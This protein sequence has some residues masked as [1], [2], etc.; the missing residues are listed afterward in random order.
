MKGRV[1]DEEG[2]P[3]PGVNILVEGKKLEGTYTNFT[4]EYK[5][6]VAPNATL[7]YSFIGYQPIKIEV[8][9]Q[10]IIDV[11]LELDQDVLAEVVVVGYGTQTRKDITGS[12]ADVSG[13][14]LERV[15][16]DDAAN[17][18]TGRL[19]GVRVVQNSSE[20]GAYD[21]D[22]DIRGFGEPLYIID[23]IQSDKA[24]FSRLTPAD[25]E[26]V[27]VLKDGSAS[28][29]GVQA[30]NGVVLVTTHQGEVGDM[31]IRY[32]GRYVW[33]WISSFPE[34][35]SAYDYALMWTEKEANQKFSNT[36][37]N[38]QNINF[39]YT[40]EM[41][42][43]LRIGEETNN[44]QTYDHF[45]N[46][47]NPVVT[48]QQHNITLQGGGSNFRYYNAIGYNRN[49][50]IWSSGDLYTNKYNFRS[51]MTA[52][53][54]KNL[55]F[56]TNLSYIYNDDNRPISTTQNIL[57]TIWRTP[58]TDPFYVNNNPDSLYQST[59]NDFNSPVAITNSDISGHNRLE[60][61][62]INA[63]FSLNY[64]IPGVKGLS[65]SALYSRNMRTALRE[66]YQKPFYQYRG[67]PE[68]NTF[69]PILHNFPSTLTHD[70]IRETRNQYQ[71]KVNYN[72]KF[73]KHNIGTMFVT[74]MMQSINELTSSRSNLLIDM[75]HFGA[76]DSKTY[77]VTST[78]PDEFRRLGFIGR[79]NY[80][81]AGKYLLEVSG[82]LDGS[83]KFA[84][85]SR[86][87]LFPSVSAGWVISK[88]RFMRSLAPTLTFLK[89]RGSFA[90]LGSDGGVQNFEYLSGYTFPVNGAYFGDGYYP[91][92]D[93]SVV[94]NPNLTWYESKLY[95]VGIEAQ[96]WK[97]KVIF[98]VDVF[99]RDRENL[100]SSN[101]AI[102]LPGSHGRPLPQI[103][104]N[105][106]R[107]QGFD[108]ELG[109]KGKTNKFNYR[110]KGIFSYTRRKL[111]NNLQAP[112]G[113]AYEEWRTG[114][115]NRYNDLA[116][117]YRTDGQYTSLEDI[118][119]SPTIDNNGNK[120]VIP[121]DIKYLDLNGDGIVDQRDV[122]VIGVNSGKPLYTAGLN[123][124]LIYK[125]FDLTMLW[126]GGFKQ[127]TRYSEMLQKPF[128][129][130]T[131]PPLAHFKDR[132]RL[133]DPYDQ[134][135]EWI[136]GTFPAMGDRKNYLESDFWYF[137]VSY[138][139]LKN[140]E[141]GYTLPQTV[142]K[143]LFLSSLRVYINTYNLL[144]FT[145]LYD[146]VDPESPGSRNFGYNYPLT[147]NINAG[148][149]IQF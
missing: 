8:Q 81:Y 58:V 54:S 33:S 17:S 133:A 136:M 56:K 108:I 88:E 80:N 41:L 71:F 132:T 98:G 43:R 127:N 35:V 24:T 60:D 102:E 15:T 62:R 103:N 57:K 145:N 51:N 90:Q 39:T 46:V 73:G 53:F 124:S 3:M 16:V 115:S 7:I 96:L 118:G 110:F 146:F 109:Y 100:V 104:V 52:N 113:N 48:Q 32:S 95:N 25:I 135:S 130:G 38:F 12:V 94:A 147:K 114:K 117:G 122:T 47:V 85:S 120:T 30:A 134:N 5:I 101:A 116:W 28:V 2:L 106:D 21:T 49:N 77:R 63:N 99:R 29:Y 69:E 31:K 4:G 89:V 111:L 27:S 149:D 37:V 55:S 87:G 129:W 1:F 14:E 148:I 76:S 59:L 105:S 121:G 40:P 125:N 13:Y 91:A 68:S 128:M 18:L 84:P 50:G 112:F 140:I 72:G 79:F 138:V 45:S 142:S 131:A 36:E 19:S 83:T 61:H 26:T 93:I 20:P 42:E 141:L 75:P 92:L 6:K 10:E 119:N 22:I 86:W 23:G 11:T 126:Q 65:L 70:N 9:N 67:N 64:Q 44:G 143:R 139:R 66:I 144:T 82:R 34:T 123:I 137:D 74:D 78:I 97:G 107:N